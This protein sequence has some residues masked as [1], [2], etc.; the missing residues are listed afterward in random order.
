M[1]K[2][3]VITSGKGGVG[4]TTVTVNV[5]A[6]LAQNGKSVLLVDADLGLRNLDLMLGVE[7]RIVYDVVDVLEG[8]CRVRQAIVKNKRNE[9]LALLP[10]SQTQNKDAIRP[11]QLKLLLSELRNSYDYILIDCPAGIEQGFNNAIEGA[12][13]AIIVCTPEIASVRDADRV[14]GL[15]AVSEVDSIRLVVN[16]VKQELVRKREMMSVADV[17]EIL[18]ISAIGAIPEDS[19]VVRAANLGEPLVYTA[20]SLASGEYF[21]IARKLM[22]VREA[23]ATKNSVSAWFERLF[24]IKEAG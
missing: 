24:G 13:E 6:A 3:I 21:K 18:G 8:R 19:A 4:K 2:T 20:H 12:E 15:L 22:G 17:E 14:A 16:R 7:N 10:A 1:G 11:G 9:K 5:G 23:D